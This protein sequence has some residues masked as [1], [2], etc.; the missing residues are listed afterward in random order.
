[1]KTFKRILP[2]LIACLVF[3]LGGCNAQKE[4]RQEEQRPEK[5]IP[6]TVETVTRN[7]IDETFILP[8]GLEAWEDIVLSSQIAGPIQQLHVR[9][10]DRV[11]AGTVLMEI[12]SETIRS[13]LRSDREN[14]SVISRTLERYRNLVGEGLVSKQELENLENNLTAAES[15]LRTRQLQLDKSTPRAPVSGVIDYL[16]ID[17]GEYIDAGKPLVRLVQIDRLKVIADI[18]EKDVRYLSVGDTVKVIPARIQGDDPEPISGTIDFIAFAA[19][20]TSRTYRTR[21]IIDNPGTLRPGMI[22]RAQFVRRELKQAI[23]VP[24]YAVVGTDSDTAVFVVSAD[25]ARRVP[26]VIGG[27]IGQR[28]LI[29]QGLEAGQQLIVSGQ[30]LVTDGTKISVGSN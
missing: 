18:P 19:N 25:T 10:G 23:T 21:I 28:V 17:R 26:V 15:A 11:K 24:L 3:F 14:V 1:M 2:V 9:E 5:V 20:E 30:Q 8:A 13:Q 16:Y 7:D 22:V 27:S 4:E 12:D 6:V 29:E